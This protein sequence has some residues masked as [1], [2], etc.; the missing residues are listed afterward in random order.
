MLSPCN[1]ARKVLGKPKRN[2]KKSLG[3]LRKPKE[4]LAHTGKT[5][6]YPREYSRHSSKFRKPGESPQK[7]ET[8]NG[9]LAILMLLLNFLVLSFAFPRKST[10][11]N[12]KNFDLGDGQTDGTYRTAGRVGR[13]G[14]NTVLQIYWDGE[15]RLHTFTGTDKYSVQFYGEREMQ[16]YIST[17]TER[18]SFPDLLGRRNSGSLSFLKSFFFRGVVFGQDGRTRTP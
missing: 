14:G 10:T 17:G 16:F 15:T 3:S 12:N 8:N 11:S 2:V 5:K 1:T 18:Y 6:E 4:I 13:T 9:K 7:S